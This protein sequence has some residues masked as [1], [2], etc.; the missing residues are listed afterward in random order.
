MRIPLKNFIPGI[1]WFFLVSVLLFLPGDD[2]PS[3]YPWLEMIYFDKWVHAGLFVVLTVLFMWPVAVSGMK[4]KA[5]VKWLLFIAIACSVWGLITEIIQYLLPGRNFD[6][7]DWAADTSGA[8]LAYIFVT[9][10]L[11]K[12]K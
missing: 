5:I 2:L 3:P 10:I 4:K 11:Q 9:F 7:R 1:A 6:L 8:V 12:N